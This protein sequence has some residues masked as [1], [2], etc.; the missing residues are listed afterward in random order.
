MVRPGGTPD[1]P[2]AADG[3]GAAPSLRRQAYLGKKWSR[4][5]EGQR[6]RENQENLTP[7]GGR[8]GPEDIPA[9]APPVA[10][11]SGGAKGRA[12]IVRPYDGGVKPPPYVFALPVGADV[13]I[14]PRAATQGRPYE[15]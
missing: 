6:I 8:N 3:E 14:G 11:L 9:A 2:C 1:R 5:G 7:P 10:S 12:H 4:K 13:P 15:S